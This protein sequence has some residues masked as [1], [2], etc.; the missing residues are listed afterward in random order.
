MSFVIKLLC[1]FRTEVFDFN[2]QSASSLHVLAF[3]YQYKHRNIHF[4]RKGVSVHV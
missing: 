3:Q 1:A 4:N 2:N